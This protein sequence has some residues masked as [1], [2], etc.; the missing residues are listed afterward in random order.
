MNVAEQWGKEVREVVLLEVDKLIN[1]I[2][3]RYD[4][5]E[6]NYKNDFS[7]IKENGCE[8]HD[9]LSN[10]R[11]RI[12]SCKSVN[13]FSDEVFNLFNSIRKN[14]FVINEFLLLSERKYGEK[15]FENLQKEFN[16]TFEELKE[17][18]KKLKE[19]D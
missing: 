11:D 3:S 16:I 18:Y 7:A 10:L 15:T 12:K 8:I 19:L 5:Y 1:N 9:A 2:K 17:N 4:N 6:E 13:F 14:I